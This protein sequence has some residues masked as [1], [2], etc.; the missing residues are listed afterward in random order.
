MEE[1]TKYSTSG[2]KPFRVLHVDDEPTDLEITRICLRRASNESLE[3]TSVLSAEDALAK[4]E[5]EHFDVVISDYKMPGMD[6]IQFLETM[7]KSADPTTIPFILFTGHG[8]AKVAREALNKG[9]D[10]YVT[11]NGSPIRQCNELAVTIKELLNGNF[12]SKAH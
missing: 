7:R 10:R 11:K 8:G 5:Y 1:Q 12:S 9:A 6:G 4:L 2:L 3:I